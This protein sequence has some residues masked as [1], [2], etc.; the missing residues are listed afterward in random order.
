MN[1]AFISRP[2]A[3][4]APAAPPACST[5]TAANC[6]LP[7]KTMPDITLDDSDPMTG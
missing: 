5:A 3:I 7:A 4:A 2:A 6:A 1:R